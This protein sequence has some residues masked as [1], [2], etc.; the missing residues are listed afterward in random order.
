MGKLKT[1]L[2]FAVMLMMIIGTSTANAGD[3]KKQGTL[4][5]KIVLAEATRSEGWLPVYLAKE[6]GFFKEEGLDA[7]LVTYKDGP[8]ALMGLLNG[9]AQFCIIGFEP[10][11][12]A[13]EKG[14]PS[15]VILTTL[16]SQPYMF[17]GRPGIKSIS[18]MK[19]KA[20]FAGMAGSAPYF[21]IKTAV[22]N[23]GLNPDKDVT[24]ANLEY[25]AELVA[26]T[27]GDIDG[28]YVRATRYPQVME[29][30]GNILVDATDPAQHKKIY[31]SERYEAMVVQVTDKYVKENP[32]II[33][34]FSNAVYKAMQW[35]N[36]H[37]DQEVASAVSPSF[38]GRNLDA[39]LI[40]VLRKCLSTDG[41]FSEEGYRAV[42]DFCIANG[43]IKKDVPMAE[44]IDPSFMKKAKEMIK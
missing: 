19:G 7:E 8:L 12:M 26:M 44:A 23:A 43:V 3:K 15:K 1:G 22:K 32:Q 2:I 41:Q 6:L 9:D 28:G 20:V 18:E 17:V 37:S 14:Q 33:Q 30:G 5:T 25:G 35:Q 39:P 38:P 42:I 34:A 40:K 13:F 36:T 27:R 16:N 31:G 21:F 24:F 10:V 29:V 4:L 11:L